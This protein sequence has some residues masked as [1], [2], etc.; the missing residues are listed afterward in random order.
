[1]FIDALEVDDVLA[2]LL[3]TEGFSSVEEVAFIP[4]EDLLAIEGFDQE[5]S[6]EL[7]SRAE[8]Y[9]SEKEKLNAIT[10]KK[11]IKNVNLFKCDKLIIT[12]FLF[13]KFFWYWKINFIKQKY[14][15]KEN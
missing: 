1:M 10:V 14:S 4:V 7:R 12:N 8:A 15:K 3:V 2:H 11:I 5:I 6:E 9:L 13:D